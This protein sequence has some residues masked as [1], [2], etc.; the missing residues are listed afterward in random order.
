MEKS[1]KVMEFRKLKRV[2]TL[3]MMA[4]E[5]RQQNE[6]VYK[7]K[8]HF[9]YDQLE[10][11]KWSTSIRLSICSGKFLF[12]PCISFALQ[13]VKLGILAQWILYPKVCP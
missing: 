12:Y 7:W 4:L 3:Y 6:I 13:L 1:W 10:L 9:H 8:V 11:K 5:L 2:Q